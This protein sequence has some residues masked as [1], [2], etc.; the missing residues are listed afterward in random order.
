MQTIEYKFYML[1][2]EFFL[3]ADHPI[4]GYKEKNNK[5]QYSMVNY[6]NGKI[7]LIEPIDGE[8]GDVYVGSTT[9]IYLSQRMSEHR[10]SYNLWK[11]GKRR[12]VTS[13][14]LF[15]KYGVENCQISLLENANVGSKDELKAR[16]RFHQQNMRCV[17][18]VIS[19]RTNKE[20]Y[21][22]N[23]AH[24][25][26][27]AKKYR[28][29][30]KEF[31]ARFNAVYRENNKERIAQQSLIYRENNRERIAQQGLIYRNKKKGIV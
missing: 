17:N 14:I 11:Q 1:H 15:D 21:E 2:I 6:N 31:V 19:G 20:H 7:Y 23:K 12:K 16:E 25:A 13:F 22:D 10:N 18:K 4:K 9:K 5:L 30:N 24:I 27:T 29:D 8:D 28:A 26:E 3:Y